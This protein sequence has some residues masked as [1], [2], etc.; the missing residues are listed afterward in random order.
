MAVNF[1]FSFL[2]ASITPIILLASQLFC[3][4]CFLSSQLWHASCQILPL[5]FSPHFISLFPLYNVWFLL[6][7]WT[8]CNGLPYWYL[9]GFCDIILSFPIISIL[10]AVLLPLTVGGV[11]PVRLL[12]RPLVLTDPQLSL[13]FTSSPGFQCC[14]ITQ[15]TFPYTCMHAFPIFPRK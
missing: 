15:Q 9:F 5:L 8:Y 1:I 4:N 3:W 7:T 2:V 6:P 11:L 12:G 13:L 10:L 14:P